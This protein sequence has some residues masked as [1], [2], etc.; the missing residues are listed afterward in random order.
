MRDGRLFKWQLGRRVGA[1][2]CN[3]TFEHVGSSRREAGGQ[4]VGD[5][6]PCCLTW[7]GMGV[8]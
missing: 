2:T 4:A 8:I 5:G 1:E 6:R 3:K 7:S